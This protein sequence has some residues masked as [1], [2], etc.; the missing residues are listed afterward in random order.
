MSRPDPVVDYRALLALPG[1]WSVFAAAT[2]ARLSYA[3]V[4]LALLLS[5]QSAT[6]SYA[7]AGTALGVYGL[8]TFSMP[9]KSRL[10]DAHGPRR[11]LPLLSALL[12][13][14]LLSLAAAASA[15]VT[16]VPVYLAGAAA[17]GLAAPPIGASMRAVWARLTL[18]RAHDNAP[19][20]SMPSWSPRCSLSAQS[21][22]RR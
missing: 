20:A 1:V 16:S 7:V 11:V 10:L 14:A 19:T 9:A 3:T 2:L 12:A 15:G 13:L 5:V 4:V 18:R 6:G 22:P 21:W 8:T 17:A